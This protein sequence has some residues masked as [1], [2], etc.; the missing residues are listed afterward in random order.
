MG[1]LDPFR[2][3]RQIDPAADDQDECYVPDVLIDDPDYSLE[4]FGE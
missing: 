2:A 3:E 4:R 1:Q